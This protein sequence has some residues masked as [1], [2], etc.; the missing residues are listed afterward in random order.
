MTTAT[1][2]MSDDKCYRHL[3]QGAIMVMNRKCIGICGRIQDRFIHKVGLEQQFEEF[4][5]TEQ[6][7]RKEFKELEDRLLL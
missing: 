7:G 2:V 6:D 4:T 3:E 1:D 5:G